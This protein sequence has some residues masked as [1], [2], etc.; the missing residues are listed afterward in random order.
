[1]DGNLYNICL[2]LD[3]LRASEFEIGGPASP[4]P[5]PS[6]SRPNSEPASDNGRRSRDRPRNDKQKKMSKTARNPSS[7]PSS[8]G[9]SR[10]PSRDQNRREAFGKENSALKKQK[11]I[12]GQA[13]PRSTKG[14][15]RTAKVRVAGKSN[16]KG[17][18]IKCTPSYVLRQPF[19]R[20][21]L[22]SP[23]PF[24]RRPPAV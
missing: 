17:G 20:G 14:K 9:N 2:K 24:A 11:S 18:S 8:A 21:S 4:I 10:H 16:A 19:L 7:P 6:S 23:H 13:D 5:M 22:R 15:D 1:M 12:Y 3:A